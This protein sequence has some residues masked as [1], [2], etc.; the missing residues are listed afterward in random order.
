MSNVI[1]IEELHAAP[2]LAVIEVPVPEYGEGKVLKIR[3]LPRARMKELRKAA[4]VTKAGGRVE[5]DTDKLEMLIFLE[6]VVDPKVCEADWNVLQEKAAAPIERTLK[7][8][9]KECGFDP[10]EARQMENSFR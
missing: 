6:C 5:V 2:D 10:E 9:L 3:G 4:S 7:A 8:A 1:T